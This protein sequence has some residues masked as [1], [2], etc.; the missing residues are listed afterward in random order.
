MVAALRDRCV[1]P[2][3]PAPGLPGGMR[4]RIMR[5]F[6]LTC[7]GQTIPLPRSAERLIAFLGLE[8]RPLPR[9]YVAG[10]LWLDSPQERSNARLRTTLWRV[11]L[12]GYHLIDLHCNTLRLT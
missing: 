9:Q 10:T 1:T 4:L 6:Q 3:P 5:G 12:P 11:S 7:Q 2:A 8:D